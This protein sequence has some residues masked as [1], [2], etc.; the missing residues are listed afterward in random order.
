MRIQRL[1]DNPIIVPAMEPRLGS[2]I[3]GPSLIRV[4][5]WLPSPLGRYYLYFAHHKGD[6]IR[7]ACA[8]AVEGPWRVH[9]PGALA[10]EASRFPTT[11]APRETLATM[12]QAPSAESEEERLSPHIA[13]PDVHVD[14][15]RR[16]I[17][18]YYHG[19]LADGSQR[20][21]VATSVDGLDFEARDEILALPYLRAFE[22]EGAWYGLAMPGVVYRSQDGLG[23]FERGPQLFGDDMRHA[24]LERT[25]ERTMRVY[26]TRAG[27]APERILSTSLSLEGDWRSWSTG[28]TREVLR[29]ETAWEGAELPVEPSLRGAIN[30]PVNQLRDPCVFVDGDA[31]YLLY[32]A[33]GESAIA[34]ARIDG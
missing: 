34:I 29:P 3:N 2:N 9:A 1:P 20:S 11:P 18:M 16:E 4:P 23:G 25:G 31:T 22:H 12:R 17:R 28:E 5:D 19:L 30:H 6:H 26:W 32:A 24:A 21:R 13:S 10:L 8:D 27:D 33:A 15:G 14:A 7:L